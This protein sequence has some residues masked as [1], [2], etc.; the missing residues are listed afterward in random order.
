VLARPARLL[1]SAAPFLFGLLL[2]RV[3]ACAVLL[4]AGLS[5]AA[6]AA[7]LVLRAQKAAAADG[8]AGGG[9]HGENRRQ[10]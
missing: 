2:D 5:L 10:S 7:L 4:S 8:A 1:Q 9:T 6:S 3:G